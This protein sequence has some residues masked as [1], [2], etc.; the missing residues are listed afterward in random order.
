MALFTWSSEYNLNIPQIDAQHQGLVRLINSL[1]DAMGR[2]EGR[3]A[4]A[5]I[6]ADLVNYTVVHF[7]DEEKYMQSIG[8]P[9]LAAHHTQHQAFVAKVSAF[10]ADFEAGK[11]TLTLQVMNFLKDWLR[12]HILDSDQK[13]AATR[14]AKAV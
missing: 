5:K 10:Q 13:F 6:L 2:G 12:V 7:R 1:H 3:V 14:P 11:L 8:Y 9:G 4:L